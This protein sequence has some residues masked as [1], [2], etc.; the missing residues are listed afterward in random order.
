MVLDEY[1][2]LAGSGT[3]ADTSNFTEFIQKSMKLYALNNEI[4]LGTHAAAN[5]IRGELAR[6]LR[7][8]PFQTNLLLGGY[9]AKEGPS[10]YFMDYLANFSKVQFGAHGY[11]SNFVLSIFDREWKEGLSEDEAIEIVKKCIHEL[12]T[13]FMLSQPNFTIKLVNQAGTRVIKL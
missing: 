2:L 11:A 6:A 1:K 3:A 4:S 9:D 12:H 10:L 5:F 7:K 13:R 8:G